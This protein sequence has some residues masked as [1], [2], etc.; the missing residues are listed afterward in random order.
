MRIEKAVPFQAGSGGAS[1]DAAAAL[2]GLAAM[3]GI[4][5]SDAALEAVARHLG[6]DVAFF[7]HGGCAYLEGVG[8]TFIHDLRPMKKAVA[9]IKPEG[10]V[11]TAQAY[12]T[13]DANPQP[14]PAELAS[15]VKEAADADEVPLF[16]NLAPAAEKL[17]PQLAE[18]RAWLSGFE[19]VRSELLCGS[20]AC[21]FAVCDDFAAA[22]AV[23]AAACKQGWWARATS[24]GS[25]RAMAVG[26]STGGIA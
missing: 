13:F 14:V 21:T 7:L 11:L 15:A 9:L 3:Q 8:D 4:D 1:A 2:V 10:G 20:G 23:V 12:A 19:G 6:T 18:V 26:S 16:N 5:S 24:F 25:A 17:M 22:C